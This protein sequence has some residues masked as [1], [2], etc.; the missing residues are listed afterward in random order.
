DWGLFGRMNEGYPSFPG[1]ITTHINV[2]VILSID[3]SPPFHGVVSPAGGSRTVKHPSYHQT[4]DAPAGVERQWFTDQVTF[5]GD[6]Q[7][8]GP[9]TNPATLV[10]G[11]TK[12]YKYGFPVDGS[13]RP[14]YTGGLWRKIL[15]TIAVSGK[16]A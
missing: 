6:Q 11:T 15:P 14:M 5:D 9:S 13:Y 3:D 16:Y 1:D 8:F 7:A 10:S 4:T 12:I 2:P